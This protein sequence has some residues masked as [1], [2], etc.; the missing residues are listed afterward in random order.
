MYVF[1]KIFISVFRVFLPVTKYLAIL[2]HMLSFKQYS[3]KT[4]FQF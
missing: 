4:L 1:L 2:P 3:L